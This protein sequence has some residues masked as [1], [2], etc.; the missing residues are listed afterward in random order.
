MARKEHGETL[1]EM[2]KDWIENNEINEEVDRSEEDC[3]A[4]INLGNM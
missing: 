3:E 4:W 2:K 1:E